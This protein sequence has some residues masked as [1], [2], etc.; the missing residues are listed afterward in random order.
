MDVQDIFGGLELEAQARHAHTSD[1]A[2]SVLRKRI[3]SGQLI[4]GMRLSEQPLAGALGVSRNTLREAFAMLA[5]ESIVKRIPNRGVF[6]ARPE[7]D[8]IREIYNIRRVIEP[9]AVLWGKLDEAAVARMDDAILLARQARR[10]GD[11][12]NMADANQNFHKA[13]IKLAGS[14]VLEQLMERVL[15]EMR[16]VFHSMASIPDFHSHYIERNAH[17]LELLRE[18]RQLD[19]ATSLRGY[20]DSAE[21]ELLG[22]MQKA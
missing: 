7:A 11:I 14:V 19:A 15:A 20:L 22:Y 5:A 2:A 16:L 21:A 18:G 4:P 1:W 10:R 17:L 9:S 13:I 8:D 3:A 6:V 12:L